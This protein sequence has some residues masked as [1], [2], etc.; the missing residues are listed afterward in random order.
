MHQFPKPPRG[1][2]L[3]LPTPTHMACPLLQ[4]R[5]FLKPL[6]LHEHE[7]IPNYLQ[8]AARLSAVV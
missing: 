5:P 1:H 2:G 4:A 3:H 6:C 8:G 7:I